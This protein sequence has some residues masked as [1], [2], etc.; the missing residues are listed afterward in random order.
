[1]RYGLAPVTICLATGILRADVGVGQHAHGLAE[2]Q[3]FTGGTPFDRFE[4]IEGPAQTFMINLD[5]FTAY[6]DEP[7][8]LRE[9]PPDFGRRKLF[10][11]ERHFHP[12]VEQRIH[13]H[14]RWCSP[15]DRRLDLR[16][17]GAVQTPT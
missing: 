1:T 14:L 15:P 8:G 16:T 5:P 6:Q 9:Q 17:R 11:V 3:A 7:V 10:T 13:P 12:E 2:R 4:F